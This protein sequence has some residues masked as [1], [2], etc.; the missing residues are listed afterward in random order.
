MS[1]M[2]QDLVL[3]PIVLSGALTA[4]AGVLRYPVPFAAEVV[5]VDLHVNTAPTGADL[6]LDVNKNGTSVWAAD[7][8]KRVKVLAT[9]NAATP[10][11]VTPGV[12]NGTNVPGIPVP[13]ATPVATFAAGDYI[14]VDVDQIGSTVAGSNAVLVLTLRRK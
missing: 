13:S 4:G 7:Q 8:T 2:N 3:F 1:I 12:V 11:K 9:Q 14:T 6:I 5:Q 10:V